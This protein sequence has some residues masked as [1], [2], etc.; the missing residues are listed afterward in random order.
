MKS[1]LNYVFENETAQNGFAFSFR[2]NVSR[3]ESG[4]GGY[5][6]SIQGGFQ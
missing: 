2:V 5:I 1:G 3:G 6:T 4:Q